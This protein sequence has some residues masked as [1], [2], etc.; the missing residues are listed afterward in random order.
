MSRQVSL[1]LGDSFNVA[2][3]NLGDVR[4]LRP[5]RM[6]DLQL[7]YVQRLRALKAVDEMLDALGE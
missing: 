1:P 5:N 7:E 3:A 4:P 6:A 2:N